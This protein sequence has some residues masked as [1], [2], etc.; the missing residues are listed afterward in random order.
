MRQAQPQRYLP[1]QRASQPPLG[2]PASRPPPQEL[3]TQKCSCPH[4][5]TWEGPPIPRTAWGQALGWAL[6]MTRRGRGASRSAGRQ[7]RQTSQTFCMTPAA[8]FL[9]CPLHFSLTHTRP[10]LLT[11]NLALWAWGWTVPPRWLPWPTNSGDPA[12]G[13]A[14]PEQLSKP[15][16]RRPQSLHRKMETSQGGATSYWALSSAVCAERFGILEASEDAPPPVPTPTAVSSRAEWTTRR[17]TP[18]LTLPGRWF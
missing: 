16:L 4:S 3:A 14:R 12:R 5:K 8:F 7:L 13:P 18:L 2:L 6:M 1:G 17:C 15:P 9:L 10:L 11:C